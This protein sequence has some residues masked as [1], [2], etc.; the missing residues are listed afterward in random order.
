M[1]NYQSENVVA[2]LQQCRESDG[3]RFN[4]V[5]PEPRRETQWFR[6]FEIADRSDNAAT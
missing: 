6:T 2:M 5:R 1:V 3:N 4:T